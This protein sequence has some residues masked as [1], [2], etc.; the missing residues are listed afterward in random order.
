[1]R[2]LDLVGQ[3]AKAL[4]SWM[5]DKQRVWQQ[6]VGYALEKKPDTAAAEKFALAQFRNMYG[7]WPYRSM[8]NVE[9]IRPSIEVMNKIRS[10]MI[11]YAK[12]VSR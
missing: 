3:K 12:R 4:P 11:R 6:I 1:M 9:P 8:A 7:E 5:E 10:Q 2:A